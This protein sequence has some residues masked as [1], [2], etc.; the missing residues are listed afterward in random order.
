MSWRHRITWIIHH[1]PPN[2]A[3][4]QIKNV[5]V[6]NKIS[7]VIP[8]L[9]DSAVGMAR[10][11]CMRVVYSYLRLTYS[12]FSFEALE[13]E[14]SIFQVFFFFF[15]LTTQIL[16]SQ[17]QPPSLQWP[18][19]TVATPFNLPSAALTEKIQMLIM[20]QACAHNGR[21]TSHAPIGGKKEMVFRVVLL[22]IAFLCWELCA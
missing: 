11:N 7:T 18:T 6:I 14:N 5:H 16:L 12:M 4:D 13:D 1:L 3:S 21:C 22:P 15:F 20:S 8:R 10:G 17:F 19:H 2:S 9:C